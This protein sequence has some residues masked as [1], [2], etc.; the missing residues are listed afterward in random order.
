MVRLAPPPHQTTTFVLLNFLFVFNFYYDI[1]ILSSSKF[2]Y[3][4]ILNPD[5]TIGYIF[6]LLE[7]SNF[8]FQFV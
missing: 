1:V 2:W 4:V 3:L 5:G 7:L 6:V 8:F